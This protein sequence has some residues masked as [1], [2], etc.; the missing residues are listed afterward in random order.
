MGS[1]RPH[2][3]RTGGARGL[4]WV[5]GL[6][7]LLAVLALA[8]AGCGGGDTVT[9]TSAPGSTATGVTDTSPAG[10]STTT[11]SGPAAAAFAGTTLDGEQVSLASFAGKPLVLAFWASW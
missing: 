6:L 10:T 3:A 9:A 11:S 8:L 1:H 4:A 2:T 7:S 5:G